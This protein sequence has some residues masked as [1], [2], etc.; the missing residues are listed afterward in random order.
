M[1]VLYGANLLFV[2]RRP[3]PVKVGEVVVSGVPDQPKRVVSAADLRG[4]IVILIGA[5]VAI[6]VMSEL[7]VSTV[8]P[9]VKQLG[10][11]EFFVGIIFIPLIG[12][13]AEHIVA[14]QFAGQNRMDLSLGISLGSSLQIALFVIP[15]LVFI[16]LLFPEH[17]LLVFNRYELLALATASIAAMLVSQDGELNWLEGAELLTVYIIL[18]LAF[19]AV[20]TAL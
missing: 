18:A 7:L 11:S 14:F 12:N 17:L 10:L 13:V 8:E 6:A 4:A 1:M 20:P 9:V 3:T 19:Y 16:S 15:V 2:L 5:T